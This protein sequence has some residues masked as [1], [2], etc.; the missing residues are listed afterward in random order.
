MKKVRRSA[1][2]FYWSLLAFLLILTL[3][4]PPT[5]WAKG[6]PGLTCPPPKRGVVAVSTPLAAEVGARVLEKGGNA[7]DAAAAIQFA[8]NVVEPEFSG[9]G[10]G[11]F[12]MIHLAKFGKTFILDCREKAPAAATADMF[13]DADGNALNFTLASSSGLSVGVPGTL[14]GVATALKKWGTISLAEAIKPA[15]KLAEEGFA[16]N[17][18]L[19]ADTGSSARTTYQPETKA[20]FRLPDG[21]PLP[22]G[23]L[24]KQPDLAKTLKLIARKGPDVF[25]R[26]EIAQAIIEAQLRSRTTDPALGVGR[27]TLKDLKHY[28]VA[29]RQPTVDE[30][31]GF[32]LKSM[33]PPS[34]GGLTVLQ[35]LKMM[36]RFP[37]GDADQGFGFGAT[38]TLHVMIEA[39]R[40]AFADRA[41]WMGDEDFVDVPTTGLLADPYVALRSTL[42]NVDDRMDAVVAGDPRPYDCPHHHRWAKLAAAADQPEGGHTT[43]F[44]VI[45]R[46][47]NIVSY[48][49]T[50]EQ[51]WGSGI[52]VPGYG[53]L[54]NNELTDFNFTPTYNPDPDS[55]NP[56]AN[57]VA[58]YKRPRSSMSPSI[59]FKG[60][61][62]F[63]A[64]GSPGGATIINSI[65]Q[66]TLNLVDH[67]MTI[68][69][70]ID[71]PRISVTSA[72]TGFMSREAGFSDE[73]IQGLRDL[74]H[75]VS[76]GT[77][78]I[79]SVQ[80]VYIDPNTGAFSGGA[81]SRREGT[82]IVLPR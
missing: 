16:I 26:G 59:L 79:G 29:I 5:L 4:A 52:M 46:F 78:P 48:T 71:A 24:L 61:K 56:G 69:E 25:Y 62:P 37:L 58:P 36:E 30:Y 82:V 35:M 65:L 80:A 72:G 73:V 14:L 55:F 44:S 33:S 38:K 57:D 75:S 19:A 32:T 43:H 81:D 64:Y 40:L 15:I 51:G 70:A 27:M 74:G 1:I 3:V 10:G 12:M 39:M 60:H 2:A 17:K 21:S 20:V 42:I 63:A 66:I 22:E 77:G 68:Q 31:R 76:A 67:E 23:Y 13:L 47:G 9:I 45:D 54:L 6:G 28:D 53:F 8:L 34:S 7:I 11:G 49:T 50:I 18:F 41:V